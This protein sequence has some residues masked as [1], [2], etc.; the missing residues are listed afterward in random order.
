MSDGMDSS[1]VKWNGAI[2]ARGYY[3]N[4][5]ATCNSQ[6][7][8]YYTR[9]SFIKLLSGSA[10]G[11]LCCIGMQG[12]RR[13]E[14]PIQA[15]A[16][17][18]SWRRGRES[19]QSVNVKKSPLKPRLIVVRDD[20]FIQS[21]KTTVERVR[22]MLQ[23][24]IMEL[25]GAESIRSGWREF[26][27]PSDVVGIKI[28]CLAGARMSTRPQLAHAIAKEL[29][30]AGVRGN[31]IIIWD[32]LNRELQ[33]ANYE[34]TTSGDGPLCF[35]TD[36]GG[37]DYDDELYEIGE[38]GSQLTQL[39]TTICTALINAP[40]VKDHGIVGITGALKNWLGAVHNPNKYHDN[41]G[42]PQIADLNL[43]DEIRG[44]QRL[45]ICDAFEVLYHGG[46]SFK[47]QFVTRHG[48]IILATDP[49]AVDAYCWKLI[50][51]YRKQNGLPPL[52]R[53]DRTPKYILTAADDEH[54][55]GVANIN[56]IEMVKVK[57]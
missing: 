49:V 22:K 18:D 32:R 26:F 43:L 36:T 34:V 37:V 52:D 35:G 1:P 4:P 44:K 2:C 25:T 10:F 6:H 13:S 40:V 47:P 16:G 51:Q 45:I 17:D 38:V 31:R 41:H 21:G 54:K 56:E 24:G 15:S 11:A 27:E 3:T 33:A 19:S 7:R 46:P 9:R 5:H 57:M 29:M 55:L 53:E 14:M 8:S 42:D 20:E 39:V 28:N 30:A 12:C 23:R 50:E 48:A